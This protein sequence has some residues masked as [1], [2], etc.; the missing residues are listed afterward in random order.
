MKTLALK[1]RQGI[2]N[3]HIGNH[4]IE[5]ELLLQACHP[6]ANHF[7]I[8]SDSNVAP[9]YAEPILNQLEKANKK[10]ELFTITAGEKSKTREVKQTLEDNMLA[11]AC[12]RDTAIIAIGGGVV[13]D[14]SG[15]IAATYCRGIKSIYVPTTLLAMVDAAIGGKTAV[16]TPLGKNMIGCFYQPHHVFCDVGTLATLPHDELANGLVETI[17]HALILDKDF[18]FALDKLYTQ[19]QLS[20][21]QLEQ[22]IHRSCEIKCGVVEKDECEISGMR[23][24]VNFGH[25]VA[26]GIERLMDYNVSHGQAVLIGLWVESCLSNLL[27]YLSDQEFACITNSLEKIKFSK[28][29]DL[30]IHQLDQLKENMILDK[31]SVGKQARFVLLDNIG[32]ARYHDKQFSFS[33]PEKIVDKAFILYLEVNQ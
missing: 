10:C 29:I 25:T 19:K 21:V 14:L 23:Q 3:I 22:L 17:K 8:I 11:A 18:F 5:N 28:P 32:K 24:L 20:A 15:F 12:G 7:V 9:L 4:I 6:L 31:K 16:N 2:C 1:H 26:H 27:G 30:S 13:T 33:V